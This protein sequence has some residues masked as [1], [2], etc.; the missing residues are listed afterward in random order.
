MAGAPS[1]AAS[2]VGTGDPGSSGAN[3]LTDHD[4]YQNGR[5]S[6]IVGA[7][8]SELQQIASVLSRHQSHVRQPTENLDPTLDPESE[9]FDVAQW[10]CHFVGQVNKQG[11]KATHL[12]VVFRNLDVFG[13][14]SALQLQDTVDS[15]TKHILHEFN[16]LFKSGELLAVLGRPGSG[17]STFLKSL[18]GELYGLTMGKRSLIHYNGA[19]QAQMKKEFKGEVVYNQEVD[20][21]FPHLTVGQTL[22]H[23]A[24][25]RTPSNRAEGMSRSE[26]CHYIAR[27]VMAVFGLSHTYHTKVGNDYVRGVSGGERKRVSIAEMMVAGSPISAWDN[28]TRGLDSTS[29]LKFVQA[30]RLYSNVAGSANAVAMYQASQAI[31]DEFD[32]TTVLYA[33]RQIYF[34]P[35]NAAKAFF[36]R[37]GWF[38][39][40]RQTTGDFLTSVTS[41]EERIPRPGMEQKVPRTPED[42]EQYWL[43][44][45][46]FKALQ[47][48][49]AAYDQEFQGERQVESLS[50]LRETK[51]HKQ[52]KHVRP[53]SP[54]IISIPMQIK[55]NTVRA[56]QRVW[57][58]ISATLVN[59]GANLIL[60]LIIGSIFYG[61]PDATAGF[62][63]KGSV[64]FMAILLNALT[65]ISDID[66]L[67]DQRPIVEKH[68]SYAFYHPATEA[69]AGIV[70]D[71]PIK[72]AAAVV[73]NLIAYFLAGLGRTPSQFFL[74][75]L[76][77]YISTFVMSAIFRTLAAIT[78]TVSQAMTLAG[79]LALALVMYT[80]YIIPVPRMHPWFGWVRWINPIYYAFEILVANEFHER[81]FTCSDIIPPFSP[82]QGSSWICASSG[83]VAGRETVNG[84]AYISVAYQYT[85]DHVWRNFGI[86]IGFL[87]FFVGVYFAAVELNSFVTSTAEALVFQRGHVSCHLQKGRDEE[88]GD[89][90]KDAVAAEKGA[91]DPGNSANEP[92]KD[93]FTWKDVVYDIDVKEG[94]PRL[95][96][97]V[98]GWVKPGIL[99]ALMG[100]S[101]AG[102]T[103]L[104][105]VLAQR[106]SIGV[107]TG[108]ML[109]N[110]RPFGADF[111][112]Q[113]GY[114]QQQESLRFSAMLRRP[115]TVSKAEK[116][117]FVEEVIKMLGME[118]YANAVVGIPGE[119]LNVERRKLLTIGVEL[120]AKPKLLLFLDEP[121]SGLDSQSAWAI[122][123][124]LRKLADAGQAVLCTIH[125][126][127][128]LLFQQFDRLLFLA[129]GGKTVYFGNIGQNS[130]SL[131]N[132]FEH[133]GARLCGDDE[134]PAEYMLEIVAEGINNQGQDWH[135]VWKESQESKDVLAEIDRIHASS[136]QDPPTAP[137]AGETN[138]EFAMA[139]HAQVWEVTKRIFQQYWR[140]PGYVLAKFALGIMSGLFIG[141]TFF[142]ADGTQGGTRNIVFAVF[143]VTTIFTTLVQQ[144]QPLFI[145]QRSLYEVRERPSKAYSWKAF[146]IAN[147]AVEIPYQIL[148]GILTFAC[149]Y[150]P[151]VGTGQASSR[152]GLILLFI[153]QLFIYASAFAHMTIAAMP[154]AHA[155]AGIV[156][157]L[158]MMSTIFS[159]VL[160]MRIAL[161]GFWV[162]MYYVSPF[163]Y[164]I[165]GIVSTVLHERRVEC[166]I[167]ETLIFDPPQGMNCAQYLS[168]LEGQGSG[169][170]Q[171][172]F[173][174]EACRYCGFGV[175]D[176]YLAGVD[177][178][179]EDRWR[180]FGIMWA[181]IVFNIAVAIGVYY[182]FRVRET[183]K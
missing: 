65:A 104:L 88:N 33:G 101:G 38:C 54:Y 152:Q 36:E 58:D 169:M 100:A 32:K 129:K 67:Y 141:F 97:H 70:A 2:T 66:S 183:K 50:H 9:H 19:S 124:F 112:R 158:T 4:P 37:Q 155:A 60:A 117:A 6:F 174:T 41:P 171:N 165:S 56:Y 121:T 131:L 111:Q 98:S 103:T 157:L 18:C 137:A 45:P 76:I 43:A 120:V 144:I 160:Q 116:F 170:L 132:Y 86:L 20:K 145:T 69:A 150:Y 127:N 92:Q 142:Q 119:G 7:D 53:G 3:T 109:V 64:L 139:F 177:I 125:Q 128:A 99:T 12:G 89:G 11:H 96:D 154:D 47:A 22:E 105:D 55:H 135:S 87:I 181:Y 75:F 77:S 48:E 147:I 51:N 8:V 143:M 24:A 16:G 126:P 122:C 172:P 123:V 84:D 49:M 107:V 15:E 74:Y 146:L 179:W 138:S 151:V 23:A 81:E 5:R 110:G 140:M 102:K 166:S 52:A 114:V 153:I 94:K 93:I 27:V 159:G 167:S 173:D 62:E 85:Y 106:T 180:N 91:Q 40:P 26:Y 163:T 71:L 46:E 31:Y 59:V 82:P 118:E 149:F 161:P 80:G 35:A 178:F 175:A 30:L 108:D 168:P 136:Q 130:K 176:Q 115:K 73:F 17:C 95:L 13:S 25:M 10:A 63:G 42:F 79:V 83:A 148:T 113:T 182:I 78:K 14:G 156:I 1:R 21:H 28:S 34:G 134:N 133:H 39:P 44:S 164:W 72:F 90:N 57:N 61:N 29:A 68:H 162:F